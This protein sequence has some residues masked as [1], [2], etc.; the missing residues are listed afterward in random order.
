MV[1]LK[2]THSCAYKKILET[3][4]NSKYI[5]AII[6]LIHVVYTT[7]V[8]HTGRNTIFKQDLKCGL[9]ELKEYTIFKPIISHL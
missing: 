4:N 1:V 7:R 3:K 2:K 8:I 6:Y 5:H 9:N